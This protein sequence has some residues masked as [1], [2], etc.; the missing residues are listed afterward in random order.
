LNVREHVKPFT[1]FLVVGALFFG[2]A[3][4]ANGLAIDVWHLHAFFAPLV[5][6]SVLFVLKYLVLLW[7]GTVN[8][9]F[10]RFGMANSAVTLL[11]SVA[12]WLLVDEAR[13]KGWLATGTTMAAAMLLRY[14]TLLKLRVIK[15]T[16]K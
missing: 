9:G 15:L 11:V 12:T 2:A 3:V 5:I 6:I 4:G 13:M 14:V 8:R 7:S 16:E 10:V 1:T